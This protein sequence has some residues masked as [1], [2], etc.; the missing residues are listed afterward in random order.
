MAAFD[1][2]MDAVE[3]NDLAGAVP[4][5][6]AAW[7]A[8]S[9][10]GVDGETLAVLAENRAE[11]Y[12]LTGDHAR[13]GAA[14][15]DLAGVLERH[16]EEAEERARALVSAATQYALARDLP[17]AINAADAAIALYPQ[18]AVSNRLFLALRVKAV[19]EWARGQLGPAGAAADRAL[20]VR[21]HIGASVDSTTMTT[22]MIAAVHHIMDRNGPEAAFF[23]SVA[24]DLAAVLPADDE[25]SL[26][27]RGWTSFLWSGL[28]GAE[29]EALF[30]RRFNSALLDFDDPGREEREQAQEAEGVED[31]QPLQRNP[32]RYPQHMLERGLQGVA[33]VMFDITEEGR[34]QNV[35]VVMSI[36]H[37]DF[38][39][40]A[41]R[42]VQ[43]WQ[44]TP[45]TENGVAVRREGV[46]T[47]FDYRFSD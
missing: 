14:W 40:E 44:Y 8:A 35:R 29:R 7:Q 20:R 3:A 46:V 15:Q 10:G 19:S 27:L 31:A 39:R 26:M 47:S 32:P 9:Q 6:E 13:A 43:R 22:A 17:A 4:H 33:V 11:I 16:N 36:P 38:G 41:V 28:S 5:A 1:A 18:D 24:S 30:E 12:V 23:M 2:Y 21:E 45:R 37:A 42:A 25:N 34:P